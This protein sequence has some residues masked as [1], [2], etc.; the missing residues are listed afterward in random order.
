MARYKLSPAA[1]NDLIDIYVR[2]LQEWGVEK[3]DSFQRELVSS[4]RLLAEQPGLGRDVAIRPTLQRYDV[5][6]YVVF[7]KMETDG[8]R[9]VRLLY[10]NRAMERHL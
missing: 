7:Y 9:I 8:V 4:I 1:E 3:A 10:K 5:A 6:P 2:A